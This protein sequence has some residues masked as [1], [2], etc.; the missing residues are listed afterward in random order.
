MSTTCL[1]ADKPHV[2]YH[3]S[4][5]HTNFYYSSVKYWSNTDILSKKFL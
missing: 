3:E 1:F 4:K 2:E 5:T